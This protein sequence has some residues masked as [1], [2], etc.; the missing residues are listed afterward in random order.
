MYLLL[1][2]LRKQDGNGEVS[3]KIALDLLFLSTTCVCLICFAQIECL[4]DVYWPKSSA[5]ITQKRLTAFMNQREKEKSEVV[6]ESET[7]EF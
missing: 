5:H 2:T 6:L 4:H 1:G 3:G 7:T